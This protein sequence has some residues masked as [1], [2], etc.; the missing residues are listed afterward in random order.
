MTQRGDGERRPAGSRRI[1]EDPTLRSRVTPR[2]VPGGARRCL[3]TRPP[4]RLSPPGTGDVRGPAAFGSGPASRAAAARPQKAPRPPVWGRRVCV[5]ACVCACCGTAKVALPQRGP[6]CLPGTP[7][8]LSPGPAAEAKTSA[9]RRERGCPRRR[10]RDTGADKA[11]RGGGAPEPGPKGTRRGG[12]TARRAGGSA[13]CA[14]HAVPCRAVPCACSQVATSLRH[15][16]SGLSFFFFP[17]YLF[18][19]SL[20]LSLFPSIFIPRFFFFLPSPPPLH[21]LF[22]V[23]L[24]FTL[25]FPLYLPACIFP[26][27]D[28][29]AA[30]RAG[31]QPP[32]ATCCRGCDGAP[33]LSATP[34][35]PP[36]PPPPRRRRPARFAPRP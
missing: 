29:P 11:A 36:P 13:V 9:L 16:T 17:P 35:P 19:Y 15:A 22:H 34:Q 20:P 2:A 32:A 7:P 28:I 12:G 1:P 3:S 24:P 27:I 10:L 26:F 30:G 14:C 6:G 33:R 18:I 25:Y 8:P 5:R 31:A 4:R 23:S 21:F